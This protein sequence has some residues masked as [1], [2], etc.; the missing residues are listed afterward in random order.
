[1]ATH[2]PPAA[3]RLISLIDDDDGVREGTANLLRSLGYD[4]RTFR[5]AQD[6]LDWPGLDDTVSCVIT[7]IMMPG[8]DGFDLCRRLAI[9]GHR[10]PI[11]IM[12]ALANPADQA[13]MRQCEVH[14]ILIKPCSERSL[15]D[16]VESALSGNPGAS[17]AGNAAL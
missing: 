16:C 12:T 11:I 3:L 8:I 13:R 4:V 9:D 14:G 2:S 10:F 17:S 1:M 7:D 6:F 15:M 5:S